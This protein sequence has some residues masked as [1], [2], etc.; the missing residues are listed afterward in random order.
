[1]K[2]NMHPAVG[3]GDLL[4]G[5]FVVPQNPIKGGGAKYIPHIGE[6]LPGRFA[7]PQNPL[8]Q[9]IRSGMAGLKGLGGCCC[10][11][12][13][14]GETGNAGGY[15]NGQVLPDTV[16]IGSLLKEV[17]WLT[18]AVA[19]GIGFVIAGEMRK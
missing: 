13:A 9:S 1:M 11:G 12:N 18:V 14:N 5:W 16:G 3:M 2:L 6:I 7:V 19:A 17:D 10:N 4:P 15:I 8:I